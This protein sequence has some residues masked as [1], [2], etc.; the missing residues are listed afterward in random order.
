M[1][2]IGIRAKILSIVILFFVTCMGFFLVDYFTNANWWVVHP[3]NKDVY[4][5]GELAT[6]GQVVSSDKVSLFTIDK[7]GSHYNESTLLTKATLHAVGDPQ[8][9]IPT[10]VT[11]SHKDKLIGFDFL[12]GVYNPSKKGSTINLTLNSELS[13][14]AYDALGSYKGTI[15]IYNYQTGEILCM[16]SKPSFDPEDEPDLESSDYE[17]VFINRLMNG[18]Y[19]PGSVFKIITTQAALEEIP[20]IEKRTFHCDGGIKINGEWIACT[21][22]HGDLGLEEGFAV[23]C[24]AVF[25]TLGEELGEKTL[26]EYAEKAGVTTQYEIDGNYTTKGRINLE[27][28]T[29]DEL[30]WAGIGQ[31]TDMINPM[32]YLIY[33]GAIAKGGKPTMPYYVD[34][35]KSSLGLPQYVRSNSKPQQQIQTTTANELK[36]LMRNATKVQYGDGNFPDMQLC[37]KSGTAEVGDD[38]PHSWFVGFSDNPKTPFAFVIIAENSDTGSSRARP[39]AM[40]VLPEVV[41]IMTGN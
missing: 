36:D 18:L 9:R 24:N 39:I 32:Q 2:K 12:N 22:N 28:A 16:V 37:A 26:K 23:S 33:M 30:A 7:D 21:G 38:N 31:H 19:V 3:S 34:S 13:K 40:E 41:D 14:T 25:G 29:K 11:T 15:G 1:K 35:I 20:D 6:T 27:G 17:G 5:D 4:I 10:G 8:N